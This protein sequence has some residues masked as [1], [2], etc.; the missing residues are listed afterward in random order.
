VLPQR[1]F[2]ALRGHAIQSLSSHQPAGGGVQLAQAA[3]GASGVELS[4]RG[5]PGAPPRWT[6][7]KPSRP[8]SFSPQGSCSLSRKLHLQT[9]AQPGKDLGSHPALKDPPRIPPAPRR[10]AAPRQ[11]P[12]T[13]P[14]LWAPYSPSLQWML[15]PTAGTSGQP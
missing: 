7:L 13:Q 4:G 2:H 15:R 12:Q 6:A 8:T 3:P 9:S 14:H 11:V 1:H 10:Q 5:G